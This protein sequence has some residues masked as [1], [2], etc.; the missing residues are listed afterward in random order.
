MP[1]DTYRSKA[2]QT[3]R[4][5]IVEVDA[6]VTRLS[7]LIAERKVR[8]KVGPQGA[9]AFDGLSDTDRAG[10]TDVCA[11]RRLMVKG[12]A[13]ARAAVAQA[14]RAAGRG[15][16]RHVIAQ[17]AHGHSDGRGGIVWHDHKG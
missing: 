14:E 7:A 17:G 8:V 6:V 3:L 2:G 5:R 16:D 13:L 1:C 11:Y 4:E 12:S 15:I 9:V 10:V